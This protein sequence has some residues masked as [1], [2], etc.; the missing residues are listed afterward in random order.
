MFGRDAE[1]DLADAVAASCAIPGFYRPVQIGGRRYVDGGVCSASNLDLLRREGLD[2][3]IA[4]NPLSGRPGVARRLRHEARKLIEA[5][6]DVLLI[7]PRGELR[8]NLMARGRRNEV[9]EAAHIN[10][11]ERLRDP[12]VRAQLRD[13]PPGHPLA[14]RRPAAPPAAGGTLRDDVVSARLAA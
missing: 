4:L 10:V 14:V 3:V 12:A 6:T 13:L 7:E 8:G 11:C 5:G 9:M 2:L 1:G